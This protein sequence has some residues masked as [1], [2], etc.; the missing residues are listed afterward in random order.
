MAETK[1]YNDSGALADWNV[2][3]RDSRGNV[4]ESAFYKEDG[5]LVEVQKDGGSYLNRFVYTYE[6]DSKGNWI[7][8]IMSK[9][10][11]KNGQP[12]LEPMAFRHRTI[13]Y[14]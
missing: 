3:T 11:L 13:T 1:T 9:P 7:N 4:L 6:F 2:I 12:V 14:Y 5:T 10:V 8:E